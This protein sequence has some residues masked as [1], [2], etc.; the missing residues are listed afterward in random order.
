MPG[1]CRC[2]CA[3]LPLLLAT[4]CLTAPRRR[5]LTP[6]ASLA[7]R[8]PEVARLLNA[9]LDAVREEVGASAPFL[10]EHP[11]LSLALAGGAGLAGAYAYRRWRRTQG[12]DR[13]SALTAQVWLAGCCE[14]ECSG[15]E[16][17]GGVPAG[18]TSCSRQVYPADASPTAPPPARLR[19]CAW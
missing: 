4:A 14:A 13:A 16:P 7:S 18:W 10:A 17:W 6:G 8:D 2:C 19:R 3:A 1:C 15:G 12:L 5:R 11:R 9:P